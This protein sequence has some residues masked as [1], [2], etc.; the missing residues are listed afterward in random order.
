[1]ELLN[2]GESNGKLPLK[3]AQDAAHQSHT[4]RLSG[5]CLLPKLALG[6]NTNTTT[7]TTTTTTTN[8]NNNNNNNNKKVNNYVAT[9]ANRINDLF[10]NVNKL[11]P[12]YC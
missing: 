4:G 2:A 10:A 7:T 8:N 5:L 11:P 12:D 9:L 6:L 1:L 3:R